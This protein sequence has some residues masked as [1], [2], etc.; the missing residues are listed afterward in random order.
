MASTEQ[1]RAIAAFWQW[2]RENKSNLDSL[3]E[4]SDPLWDVTLERLKAI[5]QGLWFELSNLGVT[6][7]E[8]IITVEGQTDL[9]DLVE[10]IVEEAPAD[11]N[12]KFVALKPPMG[13]DFKTTYEGIELD[14]KA[15]W[16]LPLENS[17]DPLAL[18]LRI[19]VPD[20][21]LDK[22]RS[23]HNA[24]LVILDTA[25]GER[26]AAS[27]IQHVEVR[28]LPQSPEANGYIALTELADYVEWRKRKLPK[29]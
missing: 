9:F 13:F 5:A 19:G 14:P 8:F 3:A 20:Y 26:V 10:E 25:L 15:L 7:R 6:P 23:I 28:R 12:W 1:H 27:K 16:F 17:A 24:V 11:P 2:F 22:Q 29:P 21:K 4:T 18:G